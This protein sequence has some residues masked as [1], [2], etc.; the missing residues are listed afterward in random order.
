[1]SPF[2]NA[3]MVRNRIRE[4]RQEKGLTQDNLAFQVGLT[5]QTINAIERGRFTPSIYS[6]LIISRVLKVSIDHLFW[7]EE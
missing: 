4:V 7:I 5:R 2:G 3:E 6:V 1:M